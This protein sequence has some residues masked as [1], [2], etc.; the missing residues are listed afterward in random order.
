[1]A[2]NINITINGE[3][4][5]GPAFGSAQGNVNRLSG[6]TDGL[7]HA[8]GVGLKAAAG[9]AIAA[10]A[11]LTAG[12][13]SSVKA[14]MNMEQQVADISASMGTTSEETAKLKDLITDLGI[15]PKLKVSATEAADA[16]G[17]LGTAGLS[18]DEILGGAARSTVLLAN[19]TG[20]DFGTAAAIATDAMAQFNIAAKDLDKA[21]NGITST[22]IASKFDIND[23][24]LAL[25]QA[26]GVAA[27][28]GVEFD[29]FNATIAAISPYFSSGSDAGTSFKTMLQRLIPQSTDAAEEMSKLGLTSVNTTASMQ[30]LADKGITPVQGSMWDLYNQVVKTYYAA[31][32]LEMGSSEAADK[33]NKWAQENGILQSAFFTTTGEMK[34]M[35]EISGILNT[36]FKDLS[37]VQRNQAL[38][39]IFGTDAMRAAA[40]MSGF[41]EESF[42]ELKATMAKT[43]AEDAAAKRM[44][45][46]QGVLEILSGTYETLQIQIGDKFLPVLKDMVKGFNDFLGAAAPSIVAWAG[47]LA[48]WMG[49]LSAKYLPTLLQRLQGW[50]EIAKELVGI[51]TGL[52]RVVVDFIGNTINLALWLKDAWIGAFTGMQSTTSSAMG[53][54]YDRFHMLF[55]VIKVFGQGALKEI[56]AWATGNETQFKNVT[57]IWEHVKWTANVLFTDLTNYVRSNL[58][59]WQAKLAEWGNAAWQWIVSATPVVLVRLQD[60][61]NQLWAWVANNAGAWMTKL[62]GWST[63]LWQ[64]IVDATGPTVQ[65]LAAWALSLYKWAADNSGRWVENLQ[66]W[67]I[68][69]FKWIGD[70][71]P[72]T[73]DA[74]TKWLDEM[75]T[76]SGGTGAT[77]TQIAFNRLGTVMLEALGQIG[78]SLARLALTVAGD[79]LLNFARGL[80]EWMGI[81][82]NWTAMHDH[83]IDLINGLTSALSGKAAL[84]GGVILAALVPGLGSIVTA[85]AGMAASVLGAVIPALGSMVTAF[86]G[87]VASAVGAVIPALGGV[88]AALAPFAVPIAAIV[89][90]VVGLYI[91]WQNNFMGIRDITYQALDWIRGAIANFPQTLANR[92]YEAARS[93]MLR[94]SEGLRSTAPNLGSDMANVLGGMVSVFNSAMDGFRNHVWGVMV[95]V[96]NRI[97]GALSSVNLGGIM[98]AALW[99]IIDEFNKVMDSFRNHVWGVMSGLGSRIGDGLAEGIRNSMGN[100]MNALNWITGVAPQWVR[101]ALGIHSPSTVFADIGTNIMAGLAQ[102]IAQATAMPEMALAGATG[103]MVGT[104]NTTVNRQ[105]SNTYNITNQGGASSG[106][107]I[108]QVRT[109]RGIYG[110]T[111]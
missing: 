108:E 20:A 89:A 63:A 18:V 3:D 38:S 23:Y 99:N 19:A 13:G 8:L 88:L 62:S 93:A 67:G 9:V 60:W 94:F 2:D 104:A 4:N 6:A 43:D 16:I 5:S 97:K 28:V 25:A 96:G 58:P 111:R 109:L 106:D 55:D 22:T 31:N 49:E 52:G 90:A 34:S 65:R 41:T 17:T 39:T 64:W 54:F 72:K 15:D 26:G 73:I 105:V 85:F 40:A 78:L 7:A 14:A 46:L 101:D 71:V 57:Q 103:G 95:D 61:A 11:G 59:I 50:W 69:L 56:V 10:V 98:N 53:Y 66:T 27:T 110:G 70:N 24:R 37:D 1:M 44:D 76:W 74:L 48:T 84:I 21:V 86:S 83:M 100:V 79:L 29:D 45:T 102:G 32:D 12:L 87:L 35:G 80:L 51:L 81:D 91:A 47:D 92:L 30:Y 33:F 107:P 36:A 68:A 42:A 82:L 75:L 77:Q